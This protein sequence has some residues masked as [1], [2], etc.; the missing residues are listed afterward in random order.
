M[1]DKYAHNL[2]KTCE[3]CG[4]CFLVRS[5]SEISKRKF[6]SKECQHENNK[7]D[8]IAV[9]CKNCRKIVF[10]PPCMSCKTKYCSR[11]CKLIG[12]RKTDKNGMR[13]CT[14]C[15]VSKPQ[16]DYYTPTNS[17]CSS[18]E[19]KRSDKDRITVPRRFSFSKSQ[20]KRRQLDWSITIEI[21]RFLLSQPCHYCYG[22]LDPTGIGLDRK[23]S[24]SGYTTDN[25]VPCCYVCNMVKGDTFTYEEMMEF[26]AP[27]IRATINRRQFLSKKR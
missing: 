1:E 17:R 6:C 10:V 27:A 20:A 12:C 24:A 8:K 11:Q 5:P 4:E 13:I 18:C 15:L 25:V 2:E 9:T 16:I 14:L 3:Q 26:M 23:N 19:R 7:K 21:Y 22:P